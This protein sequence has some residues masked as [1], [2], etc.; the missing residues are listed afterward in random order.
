MLRLLLFKCTD[1]I[2]HEQI[3]IITNESFL[4]ESI[5]SMNVINY[6]KSYHPTRKL[7]KARTNQAKNGAIKLDR[8]TVKWVE[9]T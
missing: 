8:E 5:N 3:E 7:F 4:T 9:N 6:L 2:N 1:T